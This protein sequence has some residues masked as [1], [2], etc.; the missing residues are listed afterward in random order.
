MKILH[1]LLLACF[2]VS[3]FSACHDELK[4][5][6]KAPVAPAKK[7]MEIKTTPELLPLRE[8]SKQIAVA[9]C[10][11]IVECRARW[12]DGDCVVGMTQDLFSLISSKKD[13]SMWPDVAKC[14]DVFQ[15]Y[16]CALVAKYKFPKE[17]GAG[18]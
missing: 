6:D 2:A 13:S 8:I 5:S 10:Q 14:Q 9:I 7:E 12:N 15:R 11:K 17:C 1:Y 4:K 3:V 18:E 16:D